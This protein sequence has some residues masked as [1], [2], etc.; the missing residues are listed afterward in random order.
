[1]TGGGGG[2]RAAGG[3]GDWEER[4]CFGIS[5]LALRRCLKELYI[6]GMVG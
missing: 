6:E 1:M 3:L 4:S 5:E 2:E